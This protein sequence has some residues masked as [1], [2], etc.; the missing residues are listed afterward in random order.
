[1]AQR[2]ANLA[3]DVCDVNM[4]S[5]ARPEKERFEPRSTTADKEPHRKADQHNDLGFTAI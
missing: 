4:Q 2:A 1:M 3:A 5:S